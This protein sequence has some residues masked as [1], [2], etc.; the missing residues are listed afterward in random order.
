MC[1]KLHVP[2]AV[3]KALCAFGKGFANA[4]QVSQQRFFRASDSCALLK[5]Q[6]VFTRD[7]S[8]FRQK[9]KRHKA[10]SRIE[11]RNVHVE[12]SRKSNMGFTQ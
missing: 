4:T 8:V 6:P 11:T 1:V 10:I 2:S 7:K 3:A 12:N 5:D 9:S